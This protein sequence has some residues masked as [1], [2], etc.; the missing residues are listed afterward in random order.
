MCH[1]P[2]VYSKRKTLSSEEASASNEAASDPVPLPM[3]RVMVSPDANVVSAFSIFGLS[4][5]STKFPV[6]GAP[7]TNH[8]RGES[9]V[10]V[11]LVCFGVAT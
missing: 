5:K 10:A 2:F 9:E 7:C 3:S 4:C 1:L 6:S 11:R 8:H